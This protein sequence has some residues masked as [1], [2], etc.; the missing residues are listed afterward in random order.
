MVNSLLGQFDAYDR[1][2]HFRQVPLAQMADV[3]TQEME[4]FAYLLTVI[5]LLMIVGILSMMLQDA[6][7]IGGS[8]ILVFLIQLVL[9]YAVSST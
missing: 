9:L 5:Q 7:Q 2:Q 3:D 6:N 1:F 4:A 8:L